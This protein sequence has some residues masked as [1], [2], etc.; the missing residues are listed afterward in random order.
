MDDPSTDEPVDG[1]PDDEDLEEVGLDERDAPW[2]NW[3]QLLIIAAAM[4]FFGGA[5]VY[6][7]DH[8][9]TDPGAADVGF[10]QDMTTHHEQAVEMAVLVLA[11]GADPTVRGFASDILIFQNRG[12]GI[13][14]TRLDDWGHDP[15]NR[16]EVAMDWMNMATAPSEMPGMATADQIAELRD[17]RGADADVLFLDL[18]A[19][20][21]RGGIHMASY[22]AQEANDPDVRI[23]AA[24]MARFQAVEINE[25][26]QT[27]QRNGYDLT[28]QPVDVPPEPDE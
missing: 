8:R 10:Y 26:A 19:E 5:I 28:I 7:L 6:F 24:R 16:P 23:L 13:M 17:A 22:A 12:L 9:Q 14:A 11:N 4:A 25:M 20:H 27:A 3:V 1:P 21:H 18:M 15:A 2:L